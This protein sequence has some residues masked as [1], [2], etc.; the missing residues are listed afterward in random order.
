VAALTAMPKPE[1]HHP[2]VYA[3]CDDGTMW[4]KVAHAS[5]WTQLPAIPGTGLATIAPP[6]P[7]PQDLDSAQ[8]AHPRRAL[9]GTIP[10]D[11]EDQNDDR[12]EWAQAAIDAFVSVCRT[13]P[14]D[15]LSD[16]LSDMGHW[17]DR[18]GT[19]MAAEIA[20]ASSHYNDETD[21]KG[22]SFDS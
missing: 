6:V 4:S 8:P 12:A 11:P 15:A 21:G 22:A 3:A 16:L 1:Y 14:E 20:R 18:N 5:G 19:T 2:A 17:C 10:P 7:P 9:P 13:D